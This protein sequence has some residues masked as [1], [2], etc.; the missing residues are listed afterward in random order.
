MQVNVPQGMG[1]GSVFPVQ[2]AGQ[3]IPML[4]LPVQTV[5]GAQPYG[6]VAYGSGGH[7]VTVKVRVGHGDPYRAVTTLIGPLVQSAS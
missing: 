2:T 1:P 3:P 4:N 5:G 7:H 6:Q